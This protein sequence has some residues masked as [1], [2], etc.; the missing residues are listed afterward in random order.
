MEPS[1]ATM[2]TF[3]FLQGLFALS[4]R[5]QTS[6]SEPVRAQYLQINSKVHTILGKGLVV[7]KVGVKLNERSIAGGGTPYHGMLESTKSPLVLASSPVMLCKITRY[8]TF[9]SVFPNHSTRL[10]RNSYIGRVSFR[11]LTCTVFECIRFRKSTDRSGNRTLS[12]VPFPQP[13]TDEG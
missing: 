2:R 5:T 4:V 1:R 8:P 13:V 3:P 7:V 6:A 10:A 11:Q 12:P 9:D